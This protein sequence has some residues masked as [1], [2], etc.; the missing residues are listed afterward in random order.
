MSTSAVQHELNWNSN[1]PQA[2]RD[3]MRM[4]DRHHLVI[5]TMPNEGR[6]VFRGYMEVRGKQGTYIVGCLLCAC[7]EG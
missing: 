3:K 6:W 4:C 2:V 7:H 1:V 5:L